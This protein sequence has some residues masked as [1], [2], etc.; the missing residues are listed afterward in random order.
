MSKQTLLTWRAYGGASV[1]YDTDRNTIR[2]DGSETEVARAAASMGQ[3]VLSHSQPPD[4]GDSTPL[5]PQTPQMCLSGPAIGRLDAFL[6]RFFPWFVIQGRQ[7]VG[8]YLTRFTLH[9]SKWGRVY[10]HHFHRGDDDPDFHDHDF[11]F[12]SLILSGGYYEHT[13][14]GTRWYGPGRVLYRPF[15]FCHRITLGTARPVWSL[16]FGGRT[17]GEWGFIKD[18]K[19]VHWKTYLGI[20]NYGETK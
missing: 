19:W 1:T 18:G 16:V 15:R 9:R 11:R 2:V 4:R 5:P 10:L 17:R 20:A 14:R 3:P 8:P 7:S 6:A 13:P 12:V